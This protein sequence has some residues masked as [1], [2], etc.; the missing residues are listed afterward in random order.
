MSIQ[1]VQTDDPSFVR[2]IH[3]KAL[4]NTDYIALQRHRREQVYFQNQ[5]NDINILKN[6]V[7][8]LSKVRE[9]MI[10]IK[11]LLKQITINKENN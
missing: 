10:E 9:E 7:Q 3:S 2:D 8:E 1:Q 6:Q 11:V 5:Q 4:L